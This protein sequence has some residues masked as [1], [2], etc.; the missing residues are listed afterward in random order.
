ME[1]TKIVCIGCP[2]GCAINITHDKESIK[3]IS[4][5]SCKN[6]LQYAKNEFTEPKR[7]LTSTVKV[8][9]GEIPCVPVKTHDPIRKDRIFECM[10]ELEQVEVTSPIKLGTVIKRNIGQTGVDLIATRTVN[11]SQ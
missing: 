8:K 10:N 1:E 11:R 2:K 6:G 7:I 3:N 9:F 4:G 5:Y